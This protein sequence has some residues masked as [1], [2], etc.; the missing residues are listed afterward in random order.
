MK[1][2][3][4]SQGWFGGLL[5][6]LSN[7]TNDSPPVIPGQQHLAVTAAGRRADHEFVGAACSEPIH[8]P[9]LGPDQGPHVLIVSCVLFHFQ[10]LRRRLNSLR[11]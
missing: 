3:E 1:S 6:D 5:S 4:S 11:A 10:L 7:F 9:G 2:D 8:L